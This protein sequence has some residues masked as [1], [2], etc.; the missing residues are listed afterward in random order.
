MDGANKQLSLDF[1]L[2]EDTCR[3][4]AHELVEAPLPYPSVPHHPHLAPLCE[5]FREG[6][7]LLD[8][9]QVAKE[10]ERGVVESDY[11]AVNSPRGI[12]SGPSEDVS[13][14][15]AFYREL[16]AL[17]LQQ[18]AELRALQERHAQQSAELLQQ[19]RHTEPPSL[20]LG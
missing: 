6:C 10:I 1:R 16:D 7:P 12:P 8:A 2:D 5:A 17:V 13:P 18:E 14:D 15:V 3:D 4:V 19:L 9:K 20:S 11:D